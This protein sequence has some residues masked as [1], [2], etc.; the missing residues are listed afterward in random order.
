MV[1]VTHLS[2]T[3]RWKEPAGGMLMAALVCSLKRPKKHGNR[4]NQGSVFSRVSPLP[5][6][7]AVAIILHAPGGEVAL[8]SELFLSFGQ[9]L[10]GGSPHPPV[11]PSPLE[12]LFRSPSVCRPN[13][14]PKAAVTCMKIEGS[15][16]ERYIR[17]GGFMLPLRPFFLSVIVLKA[18]RGSQT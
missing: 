17:E 16:K 7:R 2:M 14:L 18:Q 9:A 11:R 12:I 4:S 8:T 6:P 3:R 5:V 10:Q 1:L 13:K 15:A